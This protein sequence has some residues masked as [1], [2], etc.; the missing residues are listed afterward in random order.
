MAPALLLLRAWL[1]SAHLRQDDLALADLQRQPR[2]LSTSAAR[3]DVGVDWKAAAPERS[4]NRVLLF[5]W[6]YR[7]PHLTSSIPS[8][9]G[10]PFGIPF[11]LFLRSVEG[12]HADV[13]LV[14]DE[15]PS[16]VV[17]PPNVRHVHLS[18][19]DLATRLEAI[20]TGGKRLEGF[21]ASNRFKVNDVKPMSAVLF[22]ELL[23]GYEWWGWCDSDIWL[24]D[25][26]RMLAPYMDGPVD[27]V[28]AM[29]GRSHGPFTILRVRP[30]LDGL[31]SA[32]GPYADTVRKVLKWDRNVAFD[33][34]S[35]VANHSLR[36]DGI[37]FRTSFSGV[38]EAAKKQGALRLP[39]NDDALAKM[40]MLDCRCN[41][42]RAASAAKHG[43]SC[44]TRDALGATDFCSMTQH[45]VDGELT[46]VLR[47]RDGGEWLYCHFQCG[48][49][50]F[51]TPQYKAGGGE[52]I[53]KKLLSAKVLYSDLYDGVWGS[54]DDFI[55]KS[56]GTN[57]VS[58]VDPNQ[59]LLLQSRRD[60]Y[61]HVLGETY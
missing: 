30:D 47:N 35:A 12:S 25:V 4:K 32:A 48:K 29:P 41:R 11:R 60:W 10:K 40:W 16:D 3:D 44:S 28:S 21:R 39:R 15:P 1:A 38:L 26:S 20:F 22:P 5:S 31:L 36:E 27:Q 49:R 45:L 53:L 52:K 18:W 6:G 43:G 57:A 19:D 61:T 2:N 14:G 59:G 42:A 8:P 50:S 51:D 55:S 56:V 17:L 33:E 37:G 34:W 24:G 23:Q 58:D 9:L 54:D 7:D 13:V 46:T